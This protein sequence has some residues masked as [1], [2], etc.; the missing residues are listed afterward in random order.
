ME[1]TKVLIWIRL[2]FLLGEEI[3]QELKNEL[4]DRFP[5]VIELV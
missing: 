3:A 2:V 4:F 1:A 5:E